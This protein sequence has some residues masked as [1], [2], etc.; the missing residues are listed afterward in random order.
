[1]SS[2][3]L[4]V[5]LCW[6]MHQ[7]SY[8]VD[9]RYAQPWVYLHAIKDYTDM[10]AHIET[11]PG[12]RAVFNFVPALLDQIEHY[13]T[14]I[15]AF[16]VSGSAIPDP[17][18]DALARAELPQDPERRADLIK[19]CQHVNE[20][21]TLGRFPAFARLVALA[22]HAG[23]DAGR[24][25]SDAFLGDLLVWFHLAWLGEH[26][27]RADERVKR[28]LAQ[29]RGYSA[30]D[31]R[32]LLTVIGEL[33]DSVLARYRRLE[34]ERRIELA[35]SPQAHPILP[36]LLDLESAREALPH[37]ALP[38]NTRYPGGEERAQWH[39]REAR[40]SVVQHFGITPRGCWPSE[41]A[42]S[43]PTL[44]L[45]AEAGFSWTASGGGVLTNSLAAA[46]Q[47]V[48]CVHRPFTVD[49][50][51]C[52][53]RDDGLSDL[54]GFAYKDWHA[55]DAVANLIGHLETI[56]RHC[57]RD[58][59]IVG[60]VLDGENAWESYPENGYTFLQTL[61]RALAEHPALRLTTFSD[62]LEA[63]P[64]A[65][66]ELTTVVAGS[67]VYGT[68]STW[69]GDPDKNKAWELLLA[70]K[71]R[72]DDRRQNLPNV[73]QCEALL[74]ICEGSDWF[75]WLGDDNGAETVARFESLFRAHLKALYRAM[76]E[77]LPETLDV[78]LSRGS[79]HAA[80]H[81]MRSS[82]GQ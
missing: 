76:G 61:Y 51:A 73:A 35:V 17:L 36:L 43:T 46:H 13:R 81:V 78:P 16:L 38:S 53:F 22:R 70:A 18:L 9:G 71:R 44:G 65:S 4:N 32:L 62:Y 82:S 74:A 64:Q 29:E 27:R 14:L 77:P 12:A 56:G 45:I 21:H 54:I 20:R 25:L 68:L 15:H 60:I 8:W 30:A 1:M 75:W 63:N 52:F 3:P 66:I 57:D 11:V 42:I 49:G 28:L 19:Q 5:V 59:A 69:I 26:V 7:P 10:A 55:A 40:R 58:D 37:S 41:G 24:L 23:A 33:L 48:S 6:H 47:T 31:R 34:H 50:V 80:A 39:L 79:N 67:W 2:Q 72:F